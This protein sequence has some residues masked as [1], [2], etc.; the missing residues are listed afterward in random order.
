MSRIKDLRMKLK[1]DDIKYTL[2][3]LGVFPELETDKALI[4]PTVCH[5]AEGGSAKLYYYKNEK[6]FKCYTGCNSQFDIFDLLQKINKLRGNDSFSIKDAIEFTGVEQE[7]QYSKE[8]Y[9][10]LEYLKKLGAKSSLE[11]LGV[12][13]E[14]VLDEKILDR[15]KYN[16]VGVAT[17]LNEGISEKSM[18]K[19]KIGYD[20]IKNAIT[21][22]NYDHKGNL[23]GIR[24]R[25]LNEDAFAKYMPMIYENKILSHK[26][27]KIFYG[28]YE[29]KENIKRVKVAVIFEGEKSVLKMEDFYPDNNISLSTTGKKISLEHLNSLIELGTKEI[30]LAYDKDYKTTEEMKNKLTE[31]DNIVSLLKPYFN[32]SI[33]MDYDGKL[34]PKDSPA[35]RGKEVFDYLLKNRVKR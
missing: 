24:G 25:F 22:P 9:D 28:Y 23:V 29:N 6:I 18:K 5:N 30:V 21:I 12:A 4:Y 13:S 3:K 17:W 31:Y 27:G 15:Y 11:N 8:V 19:F 26:T 20:P 16:P 7:V 33:I 2:G 14:E 1:E 32:V 10:D 34:G 35:D